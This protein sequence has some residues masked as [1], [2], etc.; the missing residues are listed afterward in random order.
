[1]K[2]QDTIDKQSEDWINTILP[3]LRYKQDYT[4]CVGHSRKSENKIEIARPYIRLFSTGTTKIYRIV[5]LGEDLPVVEYT[6]D[7]ERELDKAF[8]EAETKHA[9]DK[10]EGW[11]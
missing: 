5:V 9:K 4:I 2:P 1:M 8:E 11:V 6:E 7:E 10:G 3:K